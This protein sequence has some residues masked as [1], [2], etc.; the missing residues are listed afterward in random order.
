MRRLVGSTAFL[1]ASA[2]GAVGCPAGSETFLSCTFE[3]G[4]K[5]V[6]TCVQSGSATYRFGRT[7]QTPDLEFSEPL[8][9][10]GYTPWSG[11]GWT[12]GEDLSFHNGDTTYRVAGLASRGPV[13]DEQ[14]LAEPSGRLTVEQDGINVAV[15]SCDAGS[16]D[17][18]WSQA[19]YNAKQDAGQC[20]NHP[21][22]TWSDCDMN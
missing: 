5:Y 6:E 22:L 10:V 16:V 18:P 20:W 12:V 7:G 8:E 2:S 11:A 9:S 3:G 19:I 14:D 21:E 1:F 15:L 17:F 13:D 4:A